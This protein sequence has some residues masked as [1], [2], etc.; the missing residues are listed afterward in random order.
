MLN[1]TPKL[2]IVPVPAVGSGDHDYCDKPRTSEEILE[3]THRIIE[4]LEATC[5]TLQV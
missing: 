5:A 2:R 1:S 4:E 3:A